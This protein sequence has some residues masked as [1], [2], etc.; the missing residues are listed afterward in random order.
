[1]LQYA[2]ILKSTHEVSSLVQLIGQGMAVQLSIGSQAS[3][4]ISEP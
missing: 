3:S 4:P 2:L 1:M